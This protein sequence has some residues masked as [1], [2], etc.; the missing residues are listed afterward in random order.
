MSNKRFGKICKKHPDLKGLRYQT[1]YN[2]VQCHKDRARAHDS[3]HRDYTLRRNREYQRDLLARRKKLLLDKYGNQC[4]RCGETDVDVLTIDHIKHDGS[5]HR[6]SLTKRGVRNPGS[7][8]VYKAILDSG[9]PD[10]YR[11]LCF[12]CNI[13]EH[14]EYVRA[15]R[16]V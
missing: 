5:S 9:L 14:I 4:S 15:N 7:M 1:S 13:K 8:K 11:T 6:R 16:I 3:K 2:C 12:N 10:G